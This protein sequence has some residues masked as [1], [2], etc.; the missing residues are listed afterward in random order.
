MDFENLL[1]TVMGKG[2]RERIVPMSLELRKV[3]VRWRKQ[4]DSEYFFPTRS[5][6]R[7]SYHNVLKEFKSL[8]E[9]LN[10]TG[11]RMSFHQLRRSFAKS[12]IQEGGSLSHLM[13]MLGHSNVTTTQRYVNLLTEDLKETHKKTS[14]LPAAKDRR[15]LYYTL[16]ENARRYVKLSMKAR[17]FWLT[18]SL[19]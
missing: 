16:P 17:G 15:A 19:Y 10:I 5:G 1:I 11:V 2:A 12:F 9:R 13:R 8:C 14:I 6:N 4:H 7:L 18:C 3:L